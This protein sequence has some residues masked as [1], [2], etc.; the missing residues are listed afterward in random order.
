M[1]ALIAFARPDFTGVLVPAHNIRRNLVLFVIVFHRA[2]TVTASAVAVGS[3]DAHGKKLAGVG[4]D[5]RE[6]LHGHGIHARQ[7]PRLAFRRTHRA[8]GSISWSPAHHL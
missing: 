3:C 7:A 5:T 1:Q 4:P 2:N 8:H 6:N